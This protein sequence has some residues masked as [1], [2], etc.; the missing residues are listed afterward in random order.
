MPL[1][2]YDKKLD[3]KFYLRRKFSVLCEIFK[4]AENVIFSKANT[5]I[6]I[7]WKFCKYL[8]KDIS[9][10]IHYLEFQMKW[11]YHKIKEIEEGRLLILVFSC[12]KFIIWGKLKLLQLNGKFYD[13][14]F[15]GSFYHRFIT[16]KASRKLIQQGFDCRLNGYN[17]KKITW[18]ITKFSKKDRETIE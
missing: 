11:N 9:L 7:H 18:N 2:I 13:E 12:I 1:L 3:F 16:N 4:S 14:D 15:L 17:L 8:L 10:T 6:K 5:H